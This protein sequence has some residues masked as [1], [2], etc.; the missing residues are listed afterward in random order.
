MYLPNPV[1]FGMNGVASLDVSCP[2]LRNA[3]LIISISNM[4]SGGTTVVS[5]G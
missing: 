3:S 1:G 5:S 4:T 2:L